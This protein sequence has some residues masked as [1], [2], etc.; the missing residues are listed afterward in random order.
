MAGSKIPSSSLDIH[1]KAGHARLNGKFA[2]SRPQ[3]GCFQGRS[4]HGRWSR[5]TNT[6]GRRVSDT[7]IIESTNSLHKNI[8]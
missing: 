7:N 2:F 6:L 8:N 4:S 1:L 3:I 5:G